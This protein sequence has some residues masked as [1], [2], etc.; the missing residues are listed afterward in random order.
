MQKEEEFRNYGFLPEPVIL[1]SVLVDCNFNKFND[2]IELYHYS[3]GWKVQNQKHD[4][5]FP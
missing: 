4:F 2:L 3:T 1:Q 5:D